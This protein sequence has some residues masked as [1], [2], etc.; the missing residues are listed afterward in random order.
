MA[1]GPGAV[2]SVIRWVVVL[3]VLS[4]CRE[5]ASL[6]AGEASP[7]A[8]ELRSISKLPCASDAD[9]VAGSLCAC[10]HERCGIFPDFAIQIG[11]TEGT[12]FPLSDRLS[13][14]KAVRADGGWIVE[15]FPGKWFS[16]RD[17]AQIFVLES[18]APWQLKKR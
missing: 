3:G 15:A 10:R 11:Q 9:C 13:T 12:C 2:V 7:D 8:G 14:R 6:D 16:T 17:A 18:P 1:V 4:S 5:K